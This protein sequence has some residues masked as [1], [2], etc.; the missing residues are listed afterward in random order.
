MQH[1]VF[2][3]VSAGA[4]SFYPKCYPSMAREIGAFKL[5]VPMSANLPL[6]TFKLNHGPAALD[7]DRDFPDE[8]G[9][10]CTVRPNLV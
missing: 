5:A 4:V 6:Q 8:Y 10:P 3:P 2:E 1:T 7:V 9:F